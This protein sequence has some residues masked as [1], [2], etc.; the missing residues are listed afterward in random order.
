MTTT[1]I[2]EPVSART[3]LFGSDH[4]AV[5]S[6]THTL[7]S[8]GITDVL[9]EALATFAETTRTA[10]VQEL[11]RVAS[12]LLAV[13]LSAVAVKA[14]RT[15]STILAA[16]R[17]TAPGP[18]TRELV[19]VATHDVSWAQEPYVELFVDGIR[20]ATVH[21]ELALDLEVT[22]LVVAIAGGRLTAVHSGRCEA[23]ASL[24]AEGRMLAKRAT[25]VELPLVLRLGDGIPL[26]GPD[27]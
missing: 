27:A 7:A 11:G 5:A 24:T 21:F 15:H 14:W 17:R 4:D 20:V 23:V 6:L 12:G 22:S 18:H 25:Q 26:I 16:A 1:D 19:E 13:D 8:G 10:A 2:A 9:G 3:I